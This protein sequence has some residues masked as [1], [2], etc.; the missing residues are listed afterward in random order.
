MVKGNDSDDMVS[1]SGLSVLRLRKLHAITYGVL[2]LYLLVDRSHF[3][4]WKESVCGG[5]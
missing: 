5:L 3:C 4:L 1:R 2:L